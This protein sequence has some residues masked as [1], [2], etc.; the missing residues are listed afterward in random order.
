[1][2]YSENSPTDYLCGSS[3]DNVAP[4]NSYFADNAT[5]C[6]TFVAIDNDPET[7]LLIS[8][9]T[10]FTHCGDV[11]INQRLADD[12]PSNITRW[13]TPNVSVDDPRIVPIP[14][15]YANTYHKHRDFNEVR[16][17]MGRPKTKMLLACFAKETNQL[18]RGKAHDAVKGKDFTTDFCFDKY[19]DKRLSY[20]EYLDQMAQHHFTLSPPGNGL[21]C[22]RTWE[23][24]YLGSIPI[25]KDNITARALD[26]LPSLRVDDWSQITEELLQRTLEFYK[27]RQCDWQRLWIPY[28]QKRFKQEIR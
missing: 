10:V 21:D 8:H 9:N 19:A 18:E 25:I 5:V 7:C 24:L 12:M 11:E 4:L 13:F 3:F 15:G 14:L 16:R 20:G 17:R 26:G 28:W 22:H 23:A 6:R 2:Q 1:M 27:T